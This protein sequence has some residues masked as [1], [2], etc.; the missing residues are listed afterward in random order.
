MPQV[1][2]TLLGNRCGGD[3]ETSSDDVMIAAARSLQEL[4]SHRLLLFMTL[5]MRYQPRLAYTGTGY[6]R[7]HI[8][9][10]VGSS[11]LNPPCCCRMLPL[12]WVA[13]V[14]TWQENIKR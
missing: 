4:Q 2:A 7:Y 3:Q 1:A 11:Q 14:Y 9:L 13:L 10:K 6:T 8:D 5:P 12:G